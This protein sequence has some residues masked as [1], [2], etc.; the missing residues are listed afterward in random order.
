MSV[1]RKQP[2]IGLGTSVG[3]CSA[4][5]TENNGTVCFLPHFLFPALLDC[6]GLLPR[7]HLVGRS[8]CVML[9]PQTTSLRVGVE[10]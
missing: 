9:H 5:S 6:G 4:G 7:V 1:W 8:L 2:I 3:V 10:L